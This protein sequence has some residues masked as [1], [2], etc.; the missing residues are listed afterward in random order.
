MDLHRDGGYSVIFM[1]GQGHAAGQSQLPK[2]VAGIIWLLTRAYVGKVQIWNTAAGAL[3]Q[4]LE[5]PEDVEWAVWHQKV[6]AVLA[7][8][9][10]GR[11]GCGWHTMDNVS[12]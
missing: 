4:C 7:G 10:T 8:Q 11:P 6:N 9:L 2:G 12:R 3:E 5:G 1:A